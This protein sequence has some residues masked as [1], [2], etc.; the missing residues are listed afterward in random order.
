V[1]QFL[2]NRGISTIL[3]I[4]FYNIN[5]KIIIIIAKTKQ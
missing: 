5:N 1:E 4:L 2:C 3:P